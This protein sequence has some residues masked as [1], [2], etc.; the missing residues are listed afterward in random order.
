MGKH[1]YGITLR[2]TG[3]RGSGTSGYRDYGRDHAVSSPGK[4]AELA[5]SSDPHFRGDAAR[6]NPEDLLVTSLSSC[7][8]LSYLHLCAVHGIVVTAYEDHATGAMIEDEISA[9]FTEVRLRPRVAVAAGSDEALALSLHE[10]AG[11]LCF[12][13]RSVNFPVLHEPV[14]VNS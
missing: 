14:I 9:R 6:F 3:N 10:K 11:A 2:W 12:I 8:M 4:S 1:E 13:A 5:L 7:H